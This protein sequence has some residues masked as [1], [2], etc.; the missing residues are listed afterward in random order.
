[1]KVAK[2]GVISTLVED[3]QHTEHGLASLPPTWRRRYLFSIGRSFSEP[4]FVAIMQFATIEPNVL[5][6]L[7]V[8]VL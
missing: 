2:N 6:N 3:F 5:G 4:G 7:N 1:M 8:W